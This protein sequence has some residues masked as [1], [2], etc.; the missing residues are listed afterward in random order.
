M[1]DLEVAVWV[2]LVGLAVWCGAVVIWFY[3][4]GGSRDISDLK[5]Q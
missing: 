3:E 2:L 4:R 1:S 5:D